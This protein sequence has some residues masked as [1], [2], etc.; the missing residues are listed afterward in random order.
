MKHINTKQYHSK[1]LQKRLWDQSNYL[2]TKAK[3]SHHKEERE[4]AYI[5]LTFVN[6]HKNPLQ[7]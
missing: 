6:R 7:H 5:A 4:E 1:T 3:Q 2:D